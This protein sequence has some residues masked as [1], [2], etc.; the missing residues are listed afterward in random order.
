MGLVFGAIAPH[1]SIAIAEWCTPEQRPLAQRTRTAFEE[2]GRRFDAARPD[3]TVLFTPHHIHLEKHMAVVVSGAMHGVLE[4]GTSRVELRA[5][6]DRDVARLLL[7][8]MNNAAIPTFALSYGATDPAA[9]VMPMDWA[10]Q[11]P[12]HFMG[13]DRV[14]IVMIAP[15]RDLPWET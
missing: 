6:V 9:S 15:A 8:A 3:V 2:L 13:R 1:G 10:T 11:I 7:T 5:K 14:P 4:G 12:I